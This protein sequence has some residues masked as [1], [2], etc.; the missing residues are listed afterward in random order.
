M[1]AHRTLALIPYIGALL[2]GSLSFPEALR[3]DD[4]ERTVAV[5]EQALKT[6]PN[7]AELWLHLGF[8]YRKQGQIDSAQTAFEKASRL[9]P[10]N[11]EAL[12]MLGLIYEN[13]RQNELAKKVWKDYLAIETDPNK[14]SMAENHLHQLSQ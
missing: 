3:A 10:K 13:K 7:N 8:A 1:K 5:L 4:R 2:L 12:F 9:N 11:T 6:D 14:R